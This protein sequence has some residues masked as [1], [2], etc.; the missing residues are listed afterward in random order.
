[1]AN[2]AA[3]RETNDT[4]G[5]KIW[6]GVWNSGG[7][8]AAS[9]FRIVNAALVNAETTVS[10]ALAIAAQTLHDAADPAAEGPVKIGFYGKAAAP[11][12][13]S[14][15]GDRVNGWALLNGAQVVN[16]S[17]A[18]ALI[19]GDATDGMKTQLT[20]ASGVLTDDA[21]FTP[22]TSRVQMAG[23]QADDTATDSV[24]E[25]DAG[26]ARMS[27]DRKVYTV[28]ALST[29][30][31]RA[32]GAALTPKFVAIACAS[33]G[34]N[35]ILAGVATKKLRVL[36]YVLVGA[37]AVNAKWQ[38]STG[39]DLTGLDYI[40][41]AGQGTSAAFNPLGHFETVAGEDLQLNLSGAVPVGGHLTYV[42]V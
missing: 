39:G 24:D 41:Q 22:A 37:A 7:A 32:G 42:E 2:P 4:T 23:F 28:S 40:A 34:D 16:L 15:D 21:A 30:D 13:V 11:P 29:S 33:S 17:A 14:A 19:P 36:S 26:A 27:L 38:S 31:L 1:M 8:A 18:G 6:N 25:G 35:T 10:G 12:D 5:A 9:L 3:P 20:S